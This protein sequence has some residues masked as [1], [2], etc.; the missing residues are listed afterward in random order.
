[1]VPDVVYNLSQLIEWNLR[2]CEFTVISDRY[3]PV[4]RLNTLYDNEGLIYNVLDHPQLT[5]LQAGR[6]EVSKL[7][8][9]DIHIVYNYGVN[10]A[11]V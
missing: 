6:N 7:T 9:F 5:S 1:M 11:S 3:V 10:L 8:D 4:H 2:E